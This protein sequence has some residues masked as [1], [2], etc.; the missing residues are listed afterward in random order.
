M[1]VPAADGTLSA[2][3]VAP[4]PDYS[5]LYRQCWTDETHCVLLFPTAEL[6]RRAHAQCLAEPNRNSNEIRS[7]C[8][9]AAPALKAASDAEPTESEEEESAAAAPR[10]A[11]RPLLFDSI[12]D[13]MVGRNVL[14][15]EGVEDEQLL[16]EAA[17][18]AA[19]PISAAAS[20]TSAVTTPTKPASA[21]AAS[22]ADSKLS[23]QPSPAATAT[24][25]SK[26][27]AKSTSKPAASNAKSKSSSM[28]VR[29]SFKLTV[30]NPFDALK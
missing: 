18:A 8:H 4:A 15:V 10:R 29:N 17:E 3:S 25:K 26:S 9:V 30:S 5:D 22:S 19:S 2:E 21:A 16:A 12:S 28:T 23:A 13:S 1:L 24:S 14:C 6:A 27:K 20:P 7:S 11:V